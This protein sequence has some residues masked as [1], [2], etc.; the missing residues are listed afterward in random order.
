MV[1]GTPLAEGSGVSLVAGFFWK[2]PI[3]EPEI[4]K[5]MSINSLRDLFF[6]Q[7]RDLHSVELQ[8]PDALRDLER[9]ATA[10]PLKE[11]FRKHAEVTAVQRERL[12]RIFATHRVKI[13]DDPS[14]AMQGLIKG[15]AEH[16]ASVADPTLR[17]ALIIAHTN[18]VEHYEIAAYGVAV[19][20][21]ESLGLNPEA[22]ALALSL[23]EEGRMDAAL[24]R[25]AVG[26][27]FRAG[28][29]D[30]AAAGAGRV[31]AGHQHALE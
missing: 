8:L 25:L 26:G 24:T 16:I 13:G 2:S 12:E 20:I 11:L 10:E 17:D 28:I 29:N 23:A 15:G 1:S 14:K 30:R 21:A 5:D 4:I 22:D 19:G 6:D 27:L 3:F 18:R 9:A 7:L 31:P